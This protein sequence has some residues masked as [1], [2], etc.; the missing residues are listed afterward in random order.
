MK[1]KKQ[2]KQTET[3]PCTSLVVGLTPYWRWRWRW[4]TQETEL[5][6]NSLYFYV[7]LILRLYF[8][9]SHNWLA[10]SKTLRFS[11]LSPA[12]SLFFLPHSNRF[13]FPPFISFLSFSPSSDYN[14][15]HF[16]HFQCCQL[17]RKS[18]HI[19]GGS[20]IAQNFIAIQ[21]TSLPCQF[22]FEVST[23]F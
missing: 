21:T 5:F 19:T 9:L 8:L 13:S 10:Q 18:Y 16:F 23:T 12:P 11:S 6:H 4:R 17:P 20:Y 7:S 22:Y 2:P 14:I 15:K 3:Q 1:R